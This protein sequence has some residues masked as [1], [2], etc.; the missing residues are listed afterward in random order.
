[1]KYKDMTNPP[2]LSLSTGTG[3]Q[4]RR[5]PV[6]EDYLPPCNNACPAGENIQS[7]LDLAQAERYEEAWNRLL[8]DNPMPSVHGRVCYH[9]MRDFL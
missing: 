6:Y 1:M 9:P 3:P 8:E 5:I 2:N 4:Q 7:W